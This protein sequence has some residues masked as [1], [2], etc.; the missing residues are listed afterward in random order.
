[1]L[2]E[3]GPDQADELISAVRS[4][5]ERWFDPLFEVLSTGEI[6]QGNDV[7]DAWSFLV[8]LASEA[9]AARVDESLKVLKSNV[10]SHPILVAQIASGLDSPGSDRLLEALG[11]HRD[12]EVRWTAVRAL[13][14]R[15]TTESRALL[16]NSINDPSRL[17]RS[18]V[19]DALATDSDATGRR[20]LSRFATQWATK[21]P[22][23]AAIAEQAARQ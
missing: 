13:G 20:A 18:A 11:R 14:A 15:R 1:M 4:H 3:F 17:V 2:S 6:R 9:A 8:A 12:A 22:D 21:D 10:A 7:R 5:P 19:I 23:L 16:L